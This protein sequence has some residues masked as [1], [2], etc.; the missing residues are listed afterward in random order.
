MWEN[1]RRRK[2]GNKTDVARKARQATIRKR[3]ALERDKKRRRPLGDRWDNKWDAAL[4]KTS[5]DA[6]TNSD[7]DLKIPLGGGQLNL[8][9][10]RSYR[11]LQT[12][13]EPCIPSHVLGV[14]Q[15]ISLQVSAFAC[16]CVYVP[17]TL[18]LIVGLFCF[19]RVYHFDFPLLHHECCIML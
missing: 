6:A 12:Q 4:K 10:A 16:V 1:W 11:L 5:E 2:E 17:V 19:E 18:L 8:D 9:R 14:G 13:E 15:A 3:P 7:P